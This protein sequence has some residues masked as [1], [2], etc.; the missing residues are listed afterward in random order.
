MRVGST[1]HLLAH[2]VRLFQAL[3]LLGGPGHAVRHRQVQRH[4]RARRVRGREVQEAGHGGR[5]AR[6]ARRHR[7]PVAV[8]Q[9]QAPHL[10]VLGSGFGSG[11]GLESGSGLKQL[12]LALTRM[13]RC[14]S[15]N[16]GVLSITSDLLVYYRPQA[17]S[18]RRLH[19]DAAT[20]ATDGCV[21]QFSRQHGV[22]RV[23]VPAAVGEPA[24]SASGD[25]HPTIGL[26]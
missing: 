9:R 3:E 26:L 23:S 5:V 19:V 13:R 10:R 25:G 20:M 17:K 14:N 15:L 4:R 7:E 2:L 16:A 24:A 22:A 11:L 6:V 12:G 21:D 1:S 8:L 18:T